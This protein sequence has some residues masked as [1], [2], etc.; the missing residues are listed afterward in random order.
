MQGL[1]PPGRRRRT[2]NAGGPTGSAPDPSPPSDGGTAVHDEAGPSDGSRLVAS[3]RAWAQRQEGRYHY[4]LTCSAAPDQFPAAGRLRS[5]LEASLPPLPPA[6]VAALELGWPPP[7]PGLHRIELVPGVAW[8]SVAI[9]LKPAVLRR[10]CQEASGQPAGSTR[11]PPD[12]GA[13]VVGAGLAGCAMADA[14]MRRG[15]RVTVIDAASRVG[16]A[17]A[18]VPLLAQHPALSPGDDRRSRLLLSALLNSRRLADRFGASMTWCGRFQPMPLAEARRRTAAI[19]AAIAQPIAVSEPDVHGVAGCEG[20]WYPLCAMAEPQ[21]WWE[22]LRGLA[23]LDLRLSQ[24]V[25][26]LS[27]RPGRWQAH[28][29][30]GT[31]IASAPVM[32]LANQ[33]QAL[34]LASMPDVASGQLRVS[35]VQAAIGTASPDELMSSARRRPTILG[36][37][38]YR[39]EKPGRYC[40]VGPFRVGMDSL[41]DHRITLPGLTVNDPAYRWSLCEPAERLLLRDNLPMIGAAPDTS[42]ILASRDRFE[43]N[44]RL[45]LPRQEALHLLT[46]LGGRGLLW[47]VLGA[48]MIAAALHGEPAVVEPDLQD[49]VDPARFLKRWLRRRGAG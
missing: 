25:A 32:I 9:G 15:W 2:P 47:S 27:R 42:A 13:V 41:G 18:S 8:I 26:S 3:L 29:G 37:S 11:F 34:T 16:G 48:E 4:R 5:L 14:L 44:D 19:P 1:D 49:A 7:L 21:H 31:V 38:S 39:L 40:V 22:R 20:I 30:A 6:W 17:I 43:R 35:P 10:L 36:G 12:A 23:L 24:P 46:G 33:A 28:D 45:P